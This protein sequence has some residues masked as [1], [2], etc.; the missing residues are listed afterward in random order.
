MES[1]SR[2]AE[3]ELVRE[4]P[5]RDRPRAQQ[6][7]GR[8]V[9][10]LGMQRFGVLLLGAARTKIA[11]TL[12]GPAGMG[13]LS[14]ALTLAEF[15]RQA[16]NLGTGRGFLRLVAE[17]GRAGERRRLERLIVTATIVVSIPSALLAVAC[18]IFAEPVAGWVFDDPAHAMLVRLSAIA[19][20]AAVPGAMAARVFNGLLDLR[21]FA[22]IALTQP[23]VSVVAMAALGAWRGL[24]GAVAS[25]AVAEAVG[26]L[27]GA[28]L[29]WRRVVRP[30]DL[31]LRP[32]V[33]DGQT[34]R[35]LLRYASALTVTSL[36]AAGAALLV[37]GEILRQ[38][39]A[40]ANGLYQVAWQVGQNYLGILGIS[41][42]SYGMPK[43]AS[44]LDDPEAI[45]ELQNDFLRIVVLVLAPG[46]VLLLAARDLWIPLLYS[47][48][49]LGVGA[50]IAWQLAGELF[51]AMRQSMNIT[52][53]P[54][55][56]LAFLVGQGMGYWSLW[57]ALSY[58]LLPRLGV[59]AVPGSYCAA[60]LVLLAISY[61]YHRERLG[62]RLDAGNRTLI[63][64]T[65]PGFA[66]AVL[67]TQAD[68]IVVGRVAPVACVLVWAWLH[69]SFLVRLR[70]LV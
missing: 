57:A 61:L 67:L 1:S 30:L 51:A 27:V 68:G 25:F 36:A 6:E 28:T 66:V 10:L 8:S 34:L 19:V 64:R 45:G 24:D 35:R 26:G 9:G 69:R 13:L 5:K 60:N 37:R 2:D 15:M 7:L 31:D 12:L 70:A 44:Q 17:Y 20:V 48:A 56:R 40:E 59:I 4:P 3:P 58:L 14:Q 49:F 52:L 53:L 21:A 18:A 43:V 33:P 42:W 41:L 32:R 55:E 46:I 11:A 16:G 47:R 62:Y 23:A 54:R 50:T 63:A 38:V 29:L 22:V 65:I 39:G